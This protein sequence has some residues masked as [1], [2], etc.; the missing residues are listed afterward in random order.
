MGKG[1]TKSLLGKYLARLGF[2]PIQPDD[3]RAVYIPVWFIDA[4][5]SGIVRH[6]GVEV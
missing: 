1:F 2:E 3:L 6:S 4:E 5:V